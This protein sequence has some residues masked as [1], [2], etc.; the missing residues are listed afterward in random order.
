MAKSTYII[1]YAIASIPAGSKVGP[2][3]TT[4]V[5]E[6]EHNAIAQMKK[7]FPDGKHKRLEIISIKLK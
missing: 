5:A 7:R 3:Q 6:S 1:K 2:T 4:V